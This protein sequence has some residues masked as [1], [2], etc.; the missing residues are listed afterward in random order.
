[1]THNIA[2]LGASGYTGA[3]LVRLIAT[4]PNMRITALAANSKAGQSMGQVFPHLRHLD[5]PDLVT[6]E[7]IDFSGIDLCFCA[8]PHKTSQEVIANLPRDLKIVDL[9]ADFRL[10]DPAAYE[11]WYGNPHAA[12]E[13]QQEAVYGLTEFYREDIRSARLVAGTGCNAA[14]GQYILRPLIS[15]GVID[16]DEIIL[17]LKCGVSGAG[18]SLKENLLHAELSEGYHAYSVGGTHR[19]LGEF[20]QEFSALAGRPVEIQFTPHLIPANRG[21]LATGYVRG[22]AAQ[23]HATLAAA[24]ANEPFVVVLPMGETPSTRHIRGSNFCH[25][26][27]VADRRAGRAIVI[28]ALDNLTKGSSG[29]ALQNANLM[30]SEPETTGLMLAPVFP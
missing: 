21:I 7:E 24:Y 16:L 17:D 30:L 27:V 23:I 10:R 15:A 25:I 28:A 1:M 14:T 2:I 13:V 20:D 8:L 19:H 22:E 3:E 9:S 12:P 11:K 4:H 5:L 29:Q 18:R 26:G 6:I